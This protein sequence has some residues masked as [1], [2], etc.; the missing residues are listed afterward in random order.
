MAPDVERTRSSELALVA[1]HITMEQFVEAIDQQ[2]LDADL[3]LQP[4]Y[5]LEAEEEEEEVEKNVKR[6]KVP[7]AAKFS[8]SE[9]RRNVE[10]LGLWSRIEKATGKAVPVRFYLLQRQ[11]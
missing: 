7:E 4:G 9:K 5:D 11:G 2:Q 8:P 3:H 6:R 1:R 10:E